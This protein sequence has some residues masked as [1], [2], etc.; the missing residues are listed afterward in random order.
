MLIP[1]LLYTIAIPGALALAIALIGRRREL[2]IALAVAASTIA[3]SWGVVGQPELLPDDISR[4]I[5]HVAIAGLVGAVVA[6]SGNA[7]RI[8]IARIAIAVVVC[9]MVLRPL[10][11][12]RWG[13]GG[14]L[15]LAGATL[16]LVIYTAAVE[17]V[18]QQ[19]SPRVGTTIA[20]ISA[21]AGSIA[22]AAS[23]SLVIGQVGGGLAAGVGALWALTLVRPARAVVLAHVLAPVA[24]AIVVIG[25]LYAAMPLHVAVLALLPPVVACGGLLAPPRFRATVALALALAV[26]AATLG[27][28]VKPP[29]VVEEADYGYQ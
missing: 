7:R 20:L 2:T 13:S 6:T 3:A 12:H 1:T 8:W 26:I 17:R 19:S 25:L 14:V 24:W 4:W 5:G 23:G 10:L 9:Y 22:A 11:D 21:T 18:L 29:P 27:L 28:A 16:S 15:V